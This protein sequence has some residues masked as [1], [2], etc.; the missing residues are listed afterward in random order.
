MPLLQKKTIRKFLL[1]TI[2]SRAID[3]TLVRVIILAY[4]KAVQSS[5]IF[6][7]IYFSQNLKISKLWTLTNY[8][9]IIA[10]TKVRGVLKR[11][12]QGLLNGDKQKIPNGFIDCAIMA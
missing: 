1:V 6:K 8:A 5:G 4:L 10:L 12:C 9:Q 2:H 7:I 11:S 3:I